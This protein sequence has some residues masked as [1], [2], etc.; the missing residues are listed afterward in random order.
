MADRGTLANAQFASLPLNFEMTRV[1]SSDYGAVQFNPCMGDATRFAPLQEAGRCIPSLYAGQGLRA[2]LAETVLHKVYPDDP[3]AAVREA[4]LLDRSVSVIRVARPLQM[5][6]LDTWGMG[7]M[8]LKT[9]DYFGI[10]RGYYDRCQAIALRLYQAHPQADGL[11]WVSV[12]DNSQTSYLFFGDRVGAG[13]EEVSQEPL[14]AKGAA[15]TQVLEQL[16][17]MG[18]GTP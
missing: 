12:R 17:D 4:D 8:G 16:R 13:L 14:R 7:A 5:I 3:F 10:G 1:H 9:A 6:K 2:A 11:Q 18:V 15:L